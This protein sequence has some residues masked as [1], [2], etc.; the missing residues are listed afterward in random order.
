[1]KII[2]IIKL[3]HEQFNKFDA[4]KQEIH[5]LFPTDDYDYDY[6]N[7]ELFD[8]IVNEICDKLDELI[9]VIQLDVM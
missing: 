3:R 7:K 2:F 6:N 9:N 1:M 4:I 8:E 5:S